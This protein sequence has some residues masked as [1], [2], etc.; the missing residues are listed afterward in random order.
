MGMGCRVGTENSDEKGK[1][2]GNSV[3]ECYLSA[4][5][6]VKIGNPFPFIFS[7][8]L[9]FQNVAF[10]LAVRSKNSLRTERLLRSVFKS[11]YRLV[12][13]RPCPLCT[14]A[15]SL[16][17]AWRIADDAIANIA[18]AAQRSRVT[19]TPM[20]LGCS[21]VGR[22]SKFLGRR[23]T[24][25][26]AAFGRVGEA[27]YALYS[28]TDKSSSFV[29]PIVVGA[30]ADATGDVRWGFLFAFG[31]VVVALHPRDRQRAARTE[32]CGQVC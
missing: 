30:I 11:L 24:C 10:L 28:I 3:G 4:L 21:W 12:Q 13:S 31:I 16:D 19:V 25:L 26:C 29:C 18:I 22:S 6:S 7:Q 23:V 15:P 14:L 20:A 8:R 9:A 32:G 5:F 17:C 27:R 1:I 2:W